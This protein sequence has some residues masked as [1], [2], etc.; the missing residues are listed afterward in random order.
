MFRLVLLMM[1]MLVPAFAEDELPVL[2]KGVFQGKVQD[3]TFEQPFALRLEPGQNGEVRVEMEGTDLGLKVRPQWHYPTG[4]ATPDAVY[5]S[6]ALK[7]RNDQLRIQRGSSVMLQ[8]TDKK[9]MELGDKDSENVFNVE[10]EA[11]SAPPEE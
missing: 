4:S 8:P 1:L 5:L 7:C 10:V 9:T 3:R 2:V 11:Q 6:V